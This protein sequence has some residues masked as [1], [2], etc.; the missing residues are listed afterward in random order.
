[1][2]GTVPDT[3]WAFSRHLFTML[4]KVVWAKGRATHHGAIGDRCPFVA[5][6]KAHGQP[7]ICSQLQ[8]SL[9]AQLSPSN[10]LCPAQ[11]ILLLRRQNRGFFPLHCDLPLHLAAL[12]LEENKRRLTWSRTHRLQDH[13]LQPG[14]VFPPQMKE[15]SSNCKL[16]LNCISCLMCFKIERKF[17]SHNYSHFVTKPRSFLAPSKPTYFKTEK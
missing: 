3:G 11:C 5:L 16:F 14:Q 1:M 12:T 6:H 8:A 15:T 2:P 4:M 17:F 7:S 10:N 9:P 13:P